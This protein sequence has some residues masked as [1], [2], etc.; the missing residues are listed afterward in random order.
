MLRLLRQSPPGRWTE[1]ETEYNWVHSKYN[2]SVIEDEAETKVNGTVSTPKKNY[3]FGN[4]INLNMIK[5]TLGVRLGYGCKY[6]D[7]QVLE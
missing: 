4:V 6:R 7:F 2:A 1:R 3:S 5:V